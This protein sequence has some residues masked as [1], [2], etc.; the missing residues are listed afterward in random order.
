M[1]HQQNACIQRKKNFIVLTFFSASSFLPFLPC[2]LVASYKGINTKWFY[3]NNKSK[4]K[5]GKRKCLASLDFF[6]FS[7]CFHFWFF[8]VFIQVSLNHIHPHKLTHYL[9]VL[10]ILH[11][12]FSQHNS[13][14]LIHAIKFTHFSPLVYVWL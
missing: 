6:F 9:C 13:S 12:T 14:P 1:I 11:F 4:T 8:F 10:F 7:N 2:S 3:R 5:T